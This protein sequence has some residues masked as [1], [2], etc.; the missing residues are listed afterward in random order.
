VRSFIPTPVTFQ[1]MP[2]PR[3]WALD[4]RKTDFGNVTPATTDLAQL[5]LMEFGLIYANDWFLVR[6]AFP[7]TPWLWSKA[8]R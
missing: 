5:L 6:L 1:G 2:D 4:D 7:P 3:W 8:W